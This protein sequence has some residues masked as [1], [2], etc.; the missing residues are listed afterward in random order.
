MASNKQIET[1]IVS[2]E[3]L[4]E[5]P[6]IVTYRVTF[7]IL[8]MTLLNCIDYRAIDKYTWQI[9]EKDSLN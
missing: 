3:G 4:V 8:C 1:N 2:I 9:L 5:S 7:C 6:L